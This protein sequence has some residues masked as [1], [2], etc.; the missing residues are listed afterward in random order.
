ML[1]TTKA[2][3]VSVQVGEL[4]MYFSGPKIDNVVWKNTIINE[5][6]KYSV[7]PKMSFTIF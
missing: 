5:K 1:T 7:I 3:R 6:I 2:K 4:P